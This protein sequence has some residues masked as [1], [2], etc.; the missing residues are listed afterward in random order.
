MHI[1]IE[2]KPIY[3][4]EE[5]RIEF[6]EVDGKKRKKKRSMHQYSPLIFEECYAK[7]KGLN[8]ILKSF[9]NEQDKELTA[10]IDPTGG[11]K[12]GIF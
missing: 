7:H 1:E 12:P 3:P 5:I 4:T 10:K 2:G 6:V 11:L 8:K 9:E